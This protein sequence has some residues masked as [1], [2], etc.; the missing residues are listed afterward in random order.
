M[1]GDVG[2][3]KRQEGKW[4]RASGLA[5]AF[6]SLLLMV[7]PAAAATNDP[8]AA[9]ANEPVAFEADQLFH[10]D[11]A[12][13]VTATGH[14]E[15]VQ[16]T[17]IL[18]ADKMI[19]H[20][21]TDTVS[22]LGNVSLLDEKGDVHFAQ[23]VELTGKLKEGFVQ[24]LT[25]TLADGTRFTAVEARRENGGQRMVMTEA[26]YTP[27]KVCEGKG[28][29]WQIKADKVT[30]DK[31]KKKIDYKNARLEMFGVPIGYTPIFTHPDP[32]L[33]RKSGLLRPSAG[34]TAERGTFVRGGYYVDI[35]P[36]K[37][38]TLTVEPTTRRGVLVGTQWRQR[39]ERGDLNINGSAVQSDRVEQGGTIS[40]NKLR[41]HL[42]A[43]GRYDVNERWRTGF[44]VERTS[45][46]E[47]LGLYDLSDA[48]I[49]ESEAYA[50]RF[51]GRDYS[52]V[53]AMTFQDIRV[54]VRPEQPDILPLAEHR[55]L[56][57]PGQALGGRWEVE[58]RVAG[59]NRNND[60][61]DMQKGSLDL[62]WERRFISTAGV[63]TQVEARGMADVFALQDRD[64]AKVNPALD[65]HSTAARFM[66]AA[67]VTTSL[68]VA[69]RIEGLSASLVVEPMA[70]VVVSGNL[71]QNDVDMPNEDGVGVELDAGNLFAMNRFPG[72]DRR[73]DESRAV[74]AIKGGLHGDNGR[75][76]SAM[77]GQ[78][79]RF[80]SDSGLFPDNAGLEENAS[81]LVGQLDVFLGR[82]FDA[83]YRLRV[84][85]DTLSARMHEIRASGGNDRFKLSSR[86]I[87]AEPVVGAGFSETREQVLVGGTLNLTQNW[88]L[89]SS[90][91]TDLGADPGLRRANMNLG[92]ADECF[93]FSVLGTRNLS[94][95]ATGEKETAILVRLGLKSIG[96]ISTPEIALQPS[97]SAG[98]TK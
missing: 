63:V 6:F 55:M 45:D 16:D 76:V 61:Q 72:T 35:A 22:A 28:P 58:A 52:R 10:D 93:S 5:C 81:D 85:E 31:D 95:R 34:W 23:Y 47:Y 87:F 41:G 74:Y 3:N 42:F 65:E 68:P 91:L 90:V 32:S 82:Y 97:K 15:L 56:G 36:D 30:Y 27:C 48:K 59:L 17:R 20:L 43:D 37:D 67:Q 71:D 18:R 94:D 7:R 4:R 12:Q 62:G 77:V 86:Y 14:V 19:Y 53:G 44:N 51:S 9:S 29:L 8:L 1:S 33:K 54:G 89:T 49:L 66:P 70:S 88:S 60:G 83:N 2:R 40:S 96:E 73:E 25:S 92:Y 13:T 79:Y 98:D 75:S 11:K 46:K 84:D 24:G 80:N 38:M 64:A 69:R 50:E 57:E 39:F 21:D 78:S 26:S